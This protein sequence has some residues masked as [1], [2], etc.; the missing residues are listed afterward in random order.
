MRKP[1]S[2]SQSDSSRIR[3]NTAIMKEVIPLTWPRRPVSGCGILISSLLFLPL[4]TAQSVLFQQFSAPSIIESVVAGP[5]GALWFGI[6]SGSIGRMTTNGIVTNTYQVPSA[7]SPLPVYPPYVPIGIPGIAVGSDGAVWFTEELT[8]KIGRITTGG[9]ITEYS[10]PIPSAYTL[11]Y[12]IA[13]GPDGAL[14]F[15][16]SDSSVPAA[17]IGRITT[18]GAIT[19]FS[20]PNPNA[21]PSG[22]T[23]GPDGAL[24]FTTYGY[25]IGRMTTAGVVTIFG[26][27]SGYGIATGPDGAIWFTEP[28]DSRIGRISTSGAITEFPVPTTSAVFNLWGI[29]SGSDGAIWFTEWTTNKIGRITTSGVVTEYSIPTIPNPQPSAI[30][31]GPDGAIWFAETSDI[32]RVVD[33]SPLSISTASVPNGTVGISYP[34]TV[35]QASGGVTPYSWSASGLPPGLLL[36]AGGTLSGTPSVAGTFNPTF[37]VTDSA[38]PNQAADRALAIAVAP[39]PLA[40]TT[41]SPLSS[42]SVGVAYSQNL[43]AAGGSPAYNWSLASG[44]LPSGLSLSTAGSISGIPSASGT[45]VFV[46][47][48][49]DSASV[50]TTKNL[51]LTIAAALNITTA[52]PLP[53]A[54]VGIA[55]SQNLAAAGGLPPYTW[56]L[57][58]GA[59]PSGITLTSG[60]TL[61]GT[62]TSAGNTTFSVRVVDTSSL[63]TTKAFSLTVSN[64]VTITSTSLPTGT[65]GVPYSATLAATGGTAPYINWT[66]ASGSLPPGLNLNS[67]IG[68]IS[69]TPSSSAGTPFSFSITVKDS[70]GQIS[71][72]QSLSISIAQGSP[73]ISGL[74]PSSNTAGGPEFTLSVGGS[75][76]LSGSTVEWNGSALPTSYVSGNQLTASVAPSLIAIPG[77]ASVTVANPGG[78]VSRSLIFTINAPTPSISSLSPSSVTAGGPAF[79]LTVNGSGFLSGSAVNWNGFALVSSFVSGNQLMASVAANLISAQGSASVTVVNPGGLV[80]NAATFTITARALSISSLS[81]SSTAAEGPA[82]TLTVN[83]SGFLTGS[84]VEWNGSALVTSYISGN[85]LTASVEANLIAVQG[86]A[87]VAVANPGGIVSNTLIF[88]INSPKPMLSS[89][90]P[91][92]ATAGGPEFTLTVNGSGFLPGAG[93]RWNSNFLYTVYVNAGQLTAVVSAYQISVQGSVSVTVLNP[94]GLTSNALTFTINSPRPSIS[95]L[96]PGLAMAGGPAFTLKVNGSGFLS[97]STVEWNGSAL[98]TSYIS[99]SQLAAAVTANLIAVQGSVTVTVVNPAGIT[100]NPATLTI[101]AQ[102]SP[103]INAGG[104]VNAA[105]FVAPVTPGSIA[106]AFGDFLLTSTA[107]DTNLPLS[108]S[109]LGLSLGFSGGVAAPLFF[110][111]GSQVN[112]QVPWELGGQSQAVLAGTLNGNTG[113]GQAVT[114]AAFAPG[115]FSMNAQGTGQGAILDASYHVVDSSHPA[116]PGSTA[117]QIFCTGLGAVTNQPPTGAPALSSPLSKTTTTPTLTV[118]GISANVTFS[119]LAPGFVGEYQVNA[120]VPKGVLGGSAVPVVLAMGGAVSNTVT[121]AV[122]GTSV[123][124]LADLTVSATASPNSVTSGG[125]VTYTLTVQ[126][127]GGGAAGAVTLN[128]PLPG[129]ASFL[130]CTTSAGV[131]VAT[132]GTVTASLGAL[133]PGASAIV[134]LTVAAPPV[135]SSTIITDT[136]TVSTTSTESNLANNQASA[137]ATVAQQQVSVASVSNHSPLPLTPIYIGTTGFSVSAPVSVK[138]SNSAGFSV[139]GQALRIGADGTVVVATPFY[140]DPSTHQIAAGMVSVVLSQGTLSTPPVALSVQDLPP[141]SSYG[142]QLGEITH[143]VLVFDTLLL[144]R[145]INELQA[146]QALPGNTVDT[147]GALAT[148][149][150]LLNATIQA[151]SDVDNVSQNNSLVISNGAF[152]DGNPIQFDQN[153]L[154]MM[155]RVNAIFLSQTLALVSP[156]SSPLEPLSARPQLAKFVAPLTRH[157]VRPL[158]TNSFWMLRSM[159]AA[160]SAHKLRIRRFANVPEV[161]QTSRRDPRIKPLSASSDLKSLLDAMKTIVGAKEYVEGAE[162]AGESQNWIDT[163]QAMGTSAGG[164]LDLNTGLGLIKETDFTK[165]LGV[166]AAVVS[167]ARVVGET[168]GQL[169]AYVD[170]LATGNQALV[171][172]AVQAMSDDRSHLYETGSDLILA[173]AGGPKVPDALGNVS[174]VIN[175]VKTIYDLGT[176]ADE[177]VDSASVAIVNEAAELP[178]NYAQ[179]FGSVT[180]TFDVSNSNGVASAQSGVELSSNSTNLNSMADPNGNFQLFVPLNVPAFDY[181]NGDLQIVDPISG[182]SLVSEVIDLTGL[183]AFS[184]LVAPALS[185]ACVDDDAG[186]PD[187]DDPDCDN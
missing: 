72:A 144:G 127:I 54:I 168:F 99:G 9:T 73:I 103:S 163:V 183:T 150:A 37:S 146:F 62:P 89:L 25:G 53:P 138:F 185:A 50:T 36:G 41:A 137:I 176:S 59:L 100:S 186:D 64:G 88:T 107:M 5:D 187:E 77:T 7:S 63:S 182:T 116:I 178:P 91:S 162:Q 35:L 86:S 58:S 82:F 56:S 184:P 28:Y 30:A 167:D 27:D 85:Q 154:D 109:L 14:W 139:G 23:A 171:N 121:I 125:T 57:T 11:L 70:K 39:P 124:A 47:M 98:V 20:I 81:P 90:S 17:K 102:T 94:A 66:V 115:I 142:T 141:V 69:G 101:S 95:S 61:I 24:W 157:R 160:E 165:N 156:L 3:L 16:I 113:T 131:C 80:T 158:S 148:L 4:A 78:I 10:V 84:A 111:S 173:L 76:F 33:V 136:A 122:Q 96:S 155:D 42:G 48:V 93:V 29:T 114:L 2:S 43:S 18:A 129:G 118:G 105:S 13:S 92:S 119:G 1:M 68:V 52:S 123:P 79:T 108:T 133:A 19:E 120:I 12:A 45:S 159:L 83:G 180:G 6:S 49:T 166:A 172:V 51:S 181:S 145:R 164:Y 74:T 135:S 153:S 179:D 22:I 40:I 143:A 97:G 151:R 38:A 75:G 15:T 87:T 130:S 177:Q 161:S 26:S 44:T 71:S 46:V 60:G 149:N 65:V 104:V 175:Y 128:D 32:G 169:A 140:T 117:L 110:A 21:S 55:Y 126:N 34:N 132:A 67:S 134:V 31:A 174:T 152:P 170:G 8:G 112:F 147:S 106:S